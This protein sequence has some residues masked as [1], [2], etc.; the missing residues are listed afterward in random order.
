MMED[1]ELLY[2]FTDKLCM[3]FGEYIGFSGYKDEKFFKDT[4]DSMVV[5]VF[6]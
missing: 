1:Q 3:E 4:Y 5:A 6:E 2:K